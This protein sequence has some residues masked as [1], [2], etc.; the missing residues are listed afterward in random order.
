MKVQS[1]VSPK[2]WEIRKIVDGQ[3]FVKLRKNIETLTTEEGDVLFSYDEVEVV[4]PKIQKF[5]EFIEEY[6]DDLWSADVIE[7][8]KE[9]RNLKNVTEQLTY[10]MLMGV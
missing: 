8:V 2:K 10:E 9:I 1:T 3:A 5:D 7:N 6:F 4:I